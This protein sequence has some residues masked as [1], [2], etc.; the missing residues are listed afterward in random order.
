[1]AGIP[2]KLIYLEDM[3][4]NGTKL[5]IVCASIVDPRFR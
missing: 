4:L 2:A 3:P 5:D 1:L